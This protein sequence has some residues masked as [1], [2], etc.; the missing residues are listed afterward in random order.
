LFLEGDCLAPS[1]AGEF[2]PVG[3]PARPRSAK[4]KE[5]IAIDN[6]AM[7][8]SSNIKPRG[9]FTTNDFRISKISR[10]ARIE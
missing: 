4:L 6:P 10:V 2:R 7:V 8:G 5:S 3:P 1:E 9:A